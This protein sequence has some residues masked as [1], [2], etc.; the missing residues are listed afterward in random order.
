M[1]ME[2]YLVFF[3]NSL[4]HHQVL[5]ADELYKQLGDAFVYVAICPSNKV[6]LKGGTDYSDR[7]YCLKV[8]DSHTNHIQALELARSA[9]TCVFGAESIAFAKERARQNPNGLSFE[10][11][12]RWLKKGLVNLLSPRFIKWLWYYQTLLRRANFYKLCAS[13]Y[14]AGDHSKVLSYEGRCFKWGY[15]TEVKPNMKGSVDNTFEKGVVSFLWCARFLDW[16]HPELAVELSSLL[17]RDNRSFHLNMIGDGGLMSKIKSLIRDKG[18]EGEISLLGNLPN[19]EVIRRMRECDIF[20][21][22]SDRNEGW[23]VVANEAMSNCCLLVGSDEIGSV[24]YLVCDGYSGVVFKSKS[25]DSLYEKVNFLLE[26]PEIIKRI[27]Y[28]GYESMNKIWNPKVAANNLLQLID[29]LINGRQPSVK[30]G[31]ASIA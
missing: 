30:E 31:P 21:F 8:A 27:S 11:G 12:E 16:K 2:K 22:T 7:S 24:P 15:F 26:N 13:A 3:N 20:L 17:K 1:N 29:D 6:N 14:A 9:F 25:I 19:D 18:L 5:L 23:G 10:M 28:Q 4:N